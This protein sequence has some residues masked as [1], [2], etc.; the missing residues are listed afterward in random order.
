MGGSAIKDSKRMDL[1]DYNLLKITIESSFNKFKNE[2]NIDFNYHIVKAYKSKNDFGD[3][4]I[5][6]SSS[7]PSFKDK[8]HAWMQ[9]QF[10]N[11]EPFEFIVITLPIEDIFSIMDFN[12]K[13]AKNGSI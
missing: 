5:V 10:Y 9:E 13:E 6:V 12:Y 4:D 3:M 11:H 8:L 7:D 2:S 1:I